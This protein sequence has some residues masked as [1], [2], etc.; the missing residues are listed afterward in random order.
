[1]SATVRDLSDLPFPGYGIKYVKNV[2]KESLGWVFVVLSGL[3]T[4]TQPNGVYN[5]LLDVIYT[6]L[7]T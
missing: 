2:V 6:T 4:L 3:V 1:M 7:Y 5:F